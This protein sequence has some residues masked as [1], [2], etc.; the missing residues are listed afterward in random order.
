MKPNWIPLDSS[1]KIGQI[2]ARSHEVPCLIYKHSNRC[3][4]C[5]IAQYRLEDDWPFEANALE[6]Y[7][8]DVI[9]HRPVSLEVA[10]IFSVQHESPQILLIVNGECVHDASHL[11]ITIREIQEGLA[12]RNQLVSPSV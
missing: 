12:P 7:Y 11:D 8:L 10:D 4:I 6:P 2:I 3:E 5:H 9:Q 1:Q